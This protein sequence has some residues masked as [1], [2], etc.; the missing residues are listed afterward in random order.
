MNYDPAQQFL[1]N[2]G[3]LNKT[4]HENHSNDGAR[5]TTQDALAYW[6]LGTVAL[7]LI[8]DVAIELAIQRRDDRI[9][10]EEIDRTASQLQVVGANISN[11]RDADLTSMN[12]DGRRPYADRALT[13][14]V[15]STATEIRS[16]LQSGAGK[17]Q[18]NDQSSAPLWQAPSHELAKYVGNSR[19]HKPA[20]SNHQKRSLCYSQYGFPSRTRASAITN[21]SCRSRLKKRLYASG[22]WW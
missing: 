17:R 8:A 2:K 11:I 16:S 15:R 22:C 10:S 9:L 19:H 4:K 14:R 12:D 18:K 7:A 5:S 13:E 20:Q 3:R 6:V 1:P 21:T